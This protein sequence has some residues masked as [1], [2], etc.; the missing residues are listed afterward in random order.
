[1]R[2][3]VQ[4]A[5]MLLLAAVCAFLSNAAAGPERKLKWIGAHAETA[6]PAAPAARAAT[7][8]A[9]G[10]TTGRAFP[11][12]PD[13]PW[14]EISGDDVA[15]LHQRGDV[16]F[17]DARRTSVYRDGHIS[18]ARPFSVWE[19]DI[20]DKVKAFF[21][22]GHD[23]SGVIVVYCSGGDCED[24]HTLGQKLYMAGFDDVLVYKDGFPDWEKRGLPVTKGDKP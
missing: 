17:L 20:D 9:A 13:K 24:S 12:H 8:A 3:W 23:P 4:A 18:G 1:M 2:F 6:P 10:A 7:P 21:D 16:P 14:V 11:P 19:S 15:A 22:E 5:G